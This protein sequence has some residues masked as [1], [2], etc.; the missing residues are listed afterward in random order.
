MITRNNRLNTIRTITNEGGVQIININ[1][2]TYK[3][4]IINT[5]NRILNI[6]MTSRDKT[7]NKTR[8]G[9]WQTMAE[10]R[11]SDLNINRK[12]TDKHEDLQRV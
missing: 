1:N 10:Y 12:E 7:R 5:T 2:T 4:N 8:L 9:L 11:K 6:K 3:I